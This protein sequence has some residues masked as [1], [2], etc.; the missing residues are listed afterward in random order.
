MWKIPTAYFRE[1]VD[2]LERHV[3][4]LEARNGDTD[5]FDLEIIRADA[6]AIAQEAT[7][8][9]ADIARRQAAADGDGT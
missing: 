3:R 4:V 5:R 7:N 9:I 8:W 1:K 2:Q 6:N